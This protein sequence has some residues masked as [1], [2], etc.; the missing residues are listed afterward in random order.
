MTPFLLWFVRLMV[1]VKGQSVNYSVYHCKT[2]FEVICFDV[3]VLSE[4]GN[5]IRDEHVKLV[6]RSLSVHNVQSDCLFADTLHWW[7]FKNCPGE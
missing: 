2:V 4:K 3:K 1:V 7:E 6:G 5:P